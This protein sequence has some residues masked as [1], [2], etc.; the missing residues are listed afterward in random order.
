MR[1]RIDQPKPRKTQQAD[2]NQGNG[3][4]DHTMPIIILNLRAF[5]FREVG[6]R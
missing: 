6:D 5:V 4:Y 3:I 1:D 2:K